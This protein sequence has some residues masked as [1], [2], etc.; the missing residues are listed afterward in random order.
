MHS[1]GK[2]PIALSIAGSDSGGG[3]GVQADL[4]TFAA[5]RVHGTSAITCVTAQ[6]PVGVT[7][8]QAVRA[9]IVKLQLEAIY[10]E[11]R[12]SAVKTGMLFSEPIIRV[13]ADHLSHHRDVPLVV[14]PVMV[15]TSG[16]RLLKRS[17]FQ[18]LCA[19][20]LPLA[21]LITPNVDEASWLLEREITTR[22][23]LRL[24]GR[25]LHSRFGCAVLM[26]GG[27]LA[28]ALAK[29]DDKTRPITIQAIDFFFDGRLEIWHEARFI[30]HVSTHGTGCTLSAAI[31]AH[32]AHG[33]NL[34]DAVRLAKEDITRAIRNSVRCGRH[35]VL[36]PFNL[37]PAVHLTAK[38]AKNT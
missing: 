14:D 19:R 23:D 22:E 32:L 6:S 35:D 29:S 28:A 2:I 5:L 25:E 38:I 12:P 9:A 27:H 3:A 34:L 1:R 17:A 16:A 24:A 7:G 18:T 13:V 26:K 37:N 4:K 21:T 8:V 15:A 33:K 10:A 11:L 30:P 31:A 36:W 20:L